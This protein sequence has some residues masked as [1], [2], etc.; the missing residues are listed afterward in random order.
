MVGFLF[1]QDSTRR[2]S[3]YNPQFLPVTLIAAGLSYD[4]YSQYQDLRGAVINDIADGRAKLVS[5][6]DRKLY[7]SIAFFAAAALSFINSFESVQV[8]PI[9]NG[10]GLAYR[11]N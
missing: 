10:I 6:R 4:Y 2:K 5:E 1:S 11:F 8:I 3:V 7:L 9:K